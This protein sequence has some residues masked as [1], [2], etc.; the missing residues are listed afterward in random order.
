MPQIPETCEFDIEADHIELKTR[1][2]G[3][4]IEISRLS[5]NKEQAASLAWLVNNDNHLTIEVKIKE[6]D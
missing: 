4:H 5:L 1:F 6:G 2:N 3:D